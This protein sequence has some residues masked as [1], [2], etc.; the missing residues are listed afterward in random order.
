M[1]W[2]HGLY[3]DELDELNAK[4]S[5]AIACLIIVGGNRGSGFDV[6]RQE[7][8]PN[9]ADYVRNIRKFVEGLRMVADGMEQDAD[10][11]ERSGM[12]PPHGGEG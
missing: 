7:A 9:V 10:E 11:S 2:E 3:E 5:F 1:S 12:F 6:L 4:H 8:W